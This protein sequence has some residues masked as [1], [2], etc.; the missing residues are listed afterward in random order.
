MTRD[1]CSLRV[2]LLP[3]T[4]DRWQE[5]HRVP[6]YSSVDTDKIHSLRSTQDARSRLGYFPLND[7]NTVGLQKR[8]RTLLLLS[9]EMTRV[10]LK[11]DYILRKQSIDRIAFSV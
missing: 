9:R 1:W 5:D 2:C 4:C 3:L 10:E 11:I 8:R 7:T 6:R